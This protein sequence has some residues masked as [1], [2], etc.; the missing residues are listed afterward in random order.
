[1]KYA[2]CTS[3]GLI[4][5]GWKD[6]R[7]S[8]FHEDGTLA[9]GP[10]ALCEVQGYAYAAKLAAAELSEVLGAAGRAAELAAQAEA[11]RRRFEEAFWDEDLSTYVLALDGGG[12]PCRVRASNAGQCLFT[13]IAD[14]VR[15]RRVAADLTGRA[16]F[17][18]W[19]IRTVASTEARYNPTSYHN[20]SVWPHDNA[21]IGAGFGRYGF[22]E[23]A[24]RILAGLFDA[25]LFFELHRLPE[26]FCGFLRRPGEGPTLY[27]VS[28]AP[29]SWAS[30]AVLLLLQACLGLEVL[31]SEGKVVFS[32]PFLPGFLKEVCIRDLRVGDAVLDLSLSRH[33][34]D[35]GVNVL[36]REGGVGIVVVK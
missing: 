36:R 27:P 29:Q 10:I 12:R 5:Q 1:M 18:G 7:D 31:G 6:S 2:R 28:C 15:A 4:H 34:E 9:E 30:G 32:N 16:S 17:S 26:L 24:A 11:L 25:S 3:R 20:G 33:G 19:G 23:E 35:V 8:V 13:G 22:R 14:P 21:L